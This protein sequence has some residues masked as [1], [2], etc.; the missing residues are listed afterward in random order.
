MIKWDQALVQSVHDYKKKNNTTIEK[1]LAEMKLPI[2]SFYNAQVRF[3]KRA[4]VKPV[5]AIEIKRV[6]N[7][8]VEPVKIPMKLEMVSPNSSNK[9]VIMIAERS[10]IKSILSEVF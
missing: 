6:Y 5:A 2:G 10:Q 8:K 1:A 3:S 7:K 9:I 4:K